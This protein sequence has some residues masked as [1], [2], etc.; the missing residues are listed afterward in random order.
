MT[1]YTGWK[2]YVLH[3]VQVF[4]IQIAIWKLLTLFALRTPPQND[5]FKKMSVQQVISTSTG[6]A[7]NSTVKQV[8]VWDKM[9][10]TLNPF[11]LVHSAILWGVKGVV[12]WTSFSASVTLNG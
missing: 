5:V 6:K 11:C 8:D 2:K 7:S 9:L 10:S 4:Y 3:S 12:I 1:G